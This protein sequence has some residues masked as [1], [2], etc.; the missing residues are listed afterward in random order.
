M[1]NIIDSYSESNQN[2][3]S[4]FTGGH[5]GDGQSITGNGA[6]VGSAVFYL[7]KSGS[8]TGTATA[9][10]YAHSGTF[11]TSSVPTGAALATSDT[12]DVSTLTTS[13]QLITF[14]FS[15]VN[16]IILTYGT[17]YVISIEDPTSASPD[18]ITAGRSTNLGHAG[19]RSNDTS[20]SWS[21][22][23]TTDLCFYVYDNAKGLSDSGANYLSPHHIIVGDGMSRSEVAN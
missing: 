3:V 14:N 19:N 16:Q 23:T 15:G 10:I 13:F 7:K 20:G 4:N 11:G 22:N 5:I 21:A 12:F 17:H 6:A 9:N 8:P 1:A 2:D 18:F